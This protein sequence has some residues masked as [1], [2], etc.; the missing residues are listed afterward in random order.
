[1]LQLQACELLFHFAHLSKVGL[2][3]LVLWLVHF[4][5]EVDEEL[6]VALD[7]KVPHPQSRR[8]LQASYEAF[9]FCDIV[10][11][12]LAVLE[13]ELHGVVKLVLSGRDEHCSSPRALVRKGAVKIHDPAVWCLTS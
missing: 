6:R 3:V 7:G 1:M 4:V 2:H 12:L 8:S 5:G 9:V 10:G 11:D 13:A